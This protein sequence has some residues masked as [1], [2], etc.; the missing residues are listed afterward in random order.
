MV[1]QLNMTDRMNPMNRKEYQLTEENINAIAEEVKSFLISKKV[2]D[3]DALK[4]G[5]LM[6]EALL[7]WMDRFG[8]DRTVSVELSRLAIAKVRISLRAEQ[9]NPLAEDESESVLGSEFLQNLLDAE[10][11]STAYRYRNGCNE[12]VALAHREHRQLKIPGGAVTVAVLL[13][14]AAALLTKQLPEATSSFLVNDLATPLF[15][16]FMS[17]IVMVMGPLIFISVICGICALNDVATLS[18]IGIKAIRRFVRISLLLI[19]YSV[20]ISFLFFPGISRS[21]NGAVDFTAIFTMLLDL[22]P[23]DL[24][25]PFVESKTIQ[26][27]VIATAIG[28]ALLIL[29]EK[30]SKL[31][32]LVAEANQLIFTVMGFVSKLVPLTVFLSIYKAVTLNNLSGIASVWKLVVS[33]YVIMVPFTACMVLYVCWRRKLNVRQFLRDISGP[34]AVGFTTASGTLA[35]MKQ[36]EAAREKL[37]IDEKVVSF[38]V[39]LSH[40]MFSP[41]VIPPLVTAAFFAGVYYGTPISLPQILILY[42]LVTQLSIASPKIP[43]GIMATFMIL[44]G[45][46]GMPTDVVGLLMVANVF[47]VNMQTGLAMVIRS[48]ELEDFSHAI[49]SRTPE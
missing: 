25:S 27:I 34:A 49:G 11:T 5:L 41:S 32:T 6:E 29:D 9:Y 40:A 36:F 8:R 47:I 31:R 48:T 21:S 22:I 3:R 14:V 24:V 18:S 39:P 19:T 1:I 10:G 37:K 46:L 16:R 20:I 45:Q 7:R 33:G 35:M 23:Q 44:L 30:T 13:A 43:G 42:I 28:V 26:I 15:S 2:A 12:I 38:W 4:L 17:L